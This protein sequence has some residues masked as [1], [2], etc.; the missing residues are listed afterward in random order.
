MNELF[1]IYIA[2]LLIFLGLTLAVRTRISWAWNFL[3]VAVLLYAAM[4]KLT[5]LPRDAWMFSTVEGVH[6]KTQVAYH[7]VIPTDAIYLLLGRPGER[8]YY[9]HLPWSEE[10]Q[11]QIE[12]A[13]MKAQ[14]QHTA[15]MVDVD[16][17]SKGKLADRKSG[18]RANGRELGKGDDGRPASGGGKDGG[19]QMFYAAPV[20]AD[21]LKTPIHNRIEVK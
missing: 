8:P 9:L 1:W 14:E 12:S 13:S 19:E 16:L 11:K 2:T 7:L 21:P 17:L 3:L 18:N 20:Q 5:G 4:F 6:G 10:L 15:L